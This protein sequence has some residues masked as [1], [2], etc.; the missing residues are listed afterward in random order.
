MQAH[1]LQ[2]L[3]MQCLQTQPRQSLSTLPGPI[4]VLHQQEEQHNQTGLLFI[5]SLVKFKLTTCKT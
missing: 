3:S 4:G 2:E 1:I 5:E